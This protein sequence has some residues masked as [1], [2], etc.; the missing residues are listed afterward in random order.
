MHKTQYVPTAGDGAGIELYLATASPRRQ[1]RNCE[2]KRVAGDISGHC[3]RHDLYSRVRVGFSHAS[4]AGLPRGAFR[5]RVSM[6]DV[7]SKVGGPCA[8]DGETHRREESSRAQ[9]SESSRQVPGQSCASSPLLENGSWNPD[10]EPLRLLREARI[11]RRQRGHAGCE[12]RL[13]VRTST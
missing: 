12:K 2:E 6:S 11:L 13:R 7:T 10:G 1:A 9:A 3:A 5:W 4:K 8:R